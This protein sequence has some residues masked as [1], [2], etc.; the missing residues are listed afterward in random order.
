MG[1]SSTSDGCSRA[2]LDFFSG[3]QTW[4]P[5]HDDWRL[6]SMASRDEN[7]WKWTILRS[8]GFRKSLAA[9]Q[10]PKRWNSNW[11]LFY[12]RPQKWRKCMEKS[13]TCELW[14]KYISILYHP[15]FGSLFLP[16]L[17]V[18][19]ASLIQG[20]IL[21][22]ERQKRD[23]W[24]K[25][26]WVQFMQN[27]M[28]SFLGEIIH[29]NSGSRMDFNGSTWVGYGACSPATMDPSPNYQWNVTDEKLGPQGI[30]HR[31]LSTPTMGMMKTS[32]RSPAWPDAWR[33]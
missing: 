22:Q 5:H 25:E 17:G 31:A 29:G 21:M 14:S 13:E 4:R 2:M 18:P 3:R 12:G 7:G 1:K 27:W 11:P 32:H 19:N 9:E 15:G 28:V 6:G 30:P 16:F 23:W 20:H 26:T 33:M 24:G 10:F 8:R